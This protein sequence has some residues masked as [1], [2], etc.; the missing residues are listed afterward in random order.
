MAAETHTYEIKGMTCDHCVRSVV[1]EVGAVDGV[2]E[3][4][5]SLHDGTAIVT[6]DV[7]AAAVKEAVVEAGYEVVATR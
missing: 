4:V 7:D 6:G 5:V 1:E 2:E 3:V